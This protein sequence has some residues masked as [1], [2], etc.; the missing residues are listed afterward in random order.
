MKYSLVI[1]T[2]ICQ[3]VITVV[4]NRMVT[5]TIACSTFILPFHFTG[6]QDCTKRGPPK[7]DPLVDL[8]TGPPFEPPKLEPL[9][10][11]L[12]VRGPHFVSSPRLLVILSCF[13]I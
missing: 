4:A 2:C 6:L 8:E 13:Y 10:D 12:L 3:K 7:L 5:L 1:M 9:L 11:P